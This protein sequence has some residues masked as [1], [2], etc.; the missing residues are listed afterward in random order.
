VRSVGGR[1]LCRNL[2]VMKI[3]LTGAK[4]GHSLLKKK[5]DAL[6]MRM[7]SLL[8]QIVDVRARSARRALCG[9]RRESRL[10]EQHAPHAAGLSESAPRGT[11]GW[12]PAGGDCTPLEPCSHRLIT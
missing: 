2:G 10:R 12:R 3:K 8:K 4:K 1:N 5:A 9:G 6:T 11:R 7:R